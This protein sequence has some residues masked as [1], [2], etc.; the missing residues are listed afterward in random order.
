MKIECGQIIELLPSKVIRQI[1][2]GRD[3]CKRDHI[4]RCVG[5]SEMTYIKRNEGRFFKVLKVIDW[6]QYPKEK[7]YIIE[8]V[9][10]ANG[11]KA[12]INAPFFA[13][14]NNLI[15]SLDKILEE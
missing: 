15:K 11:W 14:K 7:G 13:V 8:L 6:P 12:N 4:G 10:K 1:C 5:H 2:P 9:S 3:K